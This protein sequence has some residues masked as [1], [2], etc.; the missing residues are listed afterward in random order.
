MKTK[1]EKF[2]AEFSDALK[3][4]GKGR[5]SNQEVPRHFRRLD[6]IARLLEGN[7]ICAAVYYHPP[8]KTLWI[9]NNKVHKTSR[10]ENNY[11]KKLNEVFNLLSQ[12]KLDIEKIIEV[13][14]DSIC[15][16]LTQEKRFE[17]AKL[18]E[19]K[20]E[21]TINKWL[22]E[23]FESGKLTKE[24]RK[25]SFEEI[26][27]N[28]NEALLHSAITKTS[29]LVRDFLKVRDFLLQSVNNP[30][31]KE[32]LTAIKKSNFKILHVEGN[33]VHAEMRLLA[34]KMAE[35]TGLVDEEIYFG[36]SKLCCNHCALALKNFNVMSR[37]VHG[38]PFNWKAPQ[39]FN[40]E[41]KGL[42][43]FFGKTAAKSW[44]KLDDNAKKDA[45]KYIETK[46]SSPIKDIKNRLM[47]ADSSESD[48]VFGLDCSSETLQEELPNW[49]LQDVWLLSELK[50][51]SSLECEKLRNIGLSWDSIVDLAKCTKKF[52]TMANHVAD[53]IE[54][55]K[56]DSEDGDE[57]FEDLMNLYDNDNS[58]FWR[59]LSTPEELKD[60]FSY[61]A[62]KAGLEANDS[63]SCSD[64]QY[65]DDCYAFLQKTFEN[66]TGY[67]YGSHSSDSENYYRS[68]AD[69][70]YSEEGS[71]AFSGSEFS[72]DE[73]QFSTSYSSY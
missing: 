30:L 41:N 57:I 59:I 27:G 23:L 38:R 7:A 66:D 40:N 25:N 22:T 56:S 2:K 46:S 49:L 13:L 54:D 26:E 45:I 21:E 29:R 58:L 55:R 44:E 63:N 53:F 42:L 19:I 69:S 35:K 8:S 9:A 31:A 11:I 70:N 51:F 39:F 72:E 32:I 37:G 52:S 34:Q 12:E 5:V 1:L 50:R 10:A 62:L 71:I 60:H 64:D 17:Q 67:D 24:W 18:K 16:N 43:T 61:S 33:N 68:D 4:A 20:I 36:I 14:T 65:P 47:E 15:L 6:S 73:Y 28:E 48:V 3:N